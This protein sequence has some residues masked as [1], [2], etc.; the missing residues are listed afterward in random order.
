MYD[1]FKKTFLNLIEII[2]FPAQ[3]KRWSENNRIK[4]FEF[5][6]IIV[7][8]PLSSVSG[9]VKNLQD[10]YRETKKIG[11]I[12]ATMAYIAKP[13]FDRLLSKG[14]GKWICICS[15]IIIYPFERK[16]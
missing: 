7:D 6:F 1:K 3:F 13:K 14:L 15:W 9:Q 2:E 8:K 12:V 4:E 16:C 11:K 10:G 5:S